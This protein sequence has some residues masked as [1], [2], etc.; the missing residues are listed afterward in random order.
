MISNVTEALN[1]E[2]VKPR[3][4]GKIMGISKRERVVQV[5]L[6]NDEDIEVQFPVNMHAEILKYFRVGGLYALR[7]YAVTRNTDIVHKLSNHVFTLQYSSMHTSR[8]K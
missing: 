2:S 6:L 4:C 3:L 5:L 1:H 8:Y 7:N